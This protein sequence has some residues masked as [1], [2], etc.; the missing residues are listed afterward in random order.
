MLEIG[1]YIDRCISCSACVEV[2]PSLIFKKE[3]K[4]VIVQGV[5]GCISCGHCVAVCPKNAITHTDF[6]EGKVHSE[7]VPNVD[8]VELLKLI[9]LRRSNRTFTKKPIPQDSINMII[10]AAYRAPTASNIQG[11]KFMYIKDR[12]LLDGIIDATLNH[13]KGLLNIIDN[14]II[15]PIALMLS[16]TVRKY[17][18]LFKRL[19]AERAKGNDPILR[20]GQALLVIYTDKSV[21]FGRED[22]NLAYQNASLIAESLGVA[23][24]YAG[25][26]CDVARSNNKINKLLG[27]HG[28]IQAGMILGMPKHRF[29]KY[30]DKKDI[31]LKVL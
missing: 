23:Q 12:E 8:G 24:V 1:L 16:P 9:K 25:F 14:P 21:R 17:L 6:G 10:E 2:C 4:E 11:L 20:G 26:M 27:I 18:K 5:S 28:T 30:I 19:I 15:R 3:G 22:A 7:D 29:T 31:D 13:Y